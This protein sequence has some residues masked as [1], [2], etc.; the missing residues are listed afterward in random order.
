SD[1]EIKINKPSRSAKLRYAIKINAAKDF[2]SAVYE[3]FKF[4]TDIEKL[5]EKL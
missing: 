4:L 2:E 1:K 3:K 5:S